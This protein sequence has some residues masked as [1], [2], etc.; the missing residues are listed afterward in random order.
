MHSTDIAPG[1]RVCDVDSKTG[2]HR[3]IQIGTPGL[4]T[5]PLSVHYPGAT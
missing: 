3:G 1:T 4:V 5:V 2:G